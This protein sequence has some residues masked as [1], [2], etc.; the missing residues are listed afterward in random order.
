MQA[1]MTRLLHYPIFI[2]TKK[3]SVFGRLYDSLCIVTPSMNQSDLYS[4]SSH[5]ILLRGDAGDMSYM[6]L[7]DS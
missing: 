2:Q 4:L 6:Y 7:S 5:P 3:A 1:R